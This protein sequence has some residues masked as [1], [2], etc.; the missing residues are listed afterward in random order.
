MLLKLFIFIISLKFIFGNENYINVHPENQRVTLNSTVTIQCRVQP[1]KN[2]KV[3]WVKSG[4]GLGE[5][6]SDIRSFGMVGNKVRYDIPNDLSA[7]N[8]DLQ[9]TDVNLEDEGDFYCQMNIKNNAITS[10]RAQLHVLV[11]SGPPKIIQIGNQGMGPE[12]L[13]NENSPIVVDNGDLMAL[14]C[15]AERGRPGARLTWM[16][17]NEIIEPDLSGNFNGIISGTITNISKK[18]VNNTKLR[19]SFSTLKA[20]VNQLLNGKSI[21]CSATNRGFE[22]FNFPEAKAKIEIHV[23]PT[24]TMDIVSQNLGNEFSENDWI[25]ISCS[26]LGR[27]DKFLW[28]WYINDNEVMNDN[29]SSYKIKAT[30][31]MNKAVVKCIANNG[32]EG[33]DLRMLNVKYGPQ[34]KD[35]SPP[36]YPAN[37]GDD[38]TLTCNTD[39]NP[40]ANI[41]WQRE[42][43]NDIIGHGTILYRKNIQ[44]LDFGTYI[45]TAGVENF[46]LK[47]KKIILAKRIKPMIRENPDHRASL[48]RSVQAKCVI[49]SIPIANHNQIMWLYRGRRLINDNTKYSIS[50]EK[51]V[52]HSISI[53]SINN[54]QASDFGQY[55]CS[56][57]TDLGSASKVMVLSKTS[58][59]PLILIVGG[60]VFITMVMMIVII[61]LCVCKRGICSNKYQKGSPTNRINSNNSTDPLKSPQ[62]E[63]DYQCQ[64][65]FFQW[66]PNNNREQVK[67]SFVRYGQDVDDRSSIRNG[68]IN[69]YRGLDMCSTYTSSIP[70]SQNGEKPIRNPDIDD[71]YKEEFYPSSNPAMMCS[72]HITPTGSG[73]INR[74]SPCNAHPYS[75]PQHQISL[76]QYNFTSFANPPYL[77]N[78]LP[79]SNNNFALPSYPVHSPSSEPGINGGSGLMIPPVLPPI[80]TNDANHNVE[81]G[82]SPQQTSFIKPG[83]TISQNMANYLSPNI[84]PKPNSYNYTLSGNSNDGNSF[85]S[86]TLDRRGPISSFT[87]VDQTT[88][89]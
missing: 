45:C 30:R 80:D 33:H 53:L 34:F 82:L 58:P 2:M 24:V 21:K 69:Q 18:I 78:Y 19:D 73:A 26:A 32:K 79:G 37:I 23:A 25:T 59:I 71:V 4:F 6:R 8:Y 11:A 77:S 40:M 65:N 5:T 54:I 3:Y 39:S 7:G 41:Y 15:Q 75:V 60:T 36:L 66:I 81:L 87:N 55:N 70:G 44:E 50:T 14:R 35:D 56:V 74:A 48:G 84:R 10:Q 68:S 67:S 88:N 64:P 29:R 27:P 85:K 51:Y 86:R 16:I 28:K 38:V 1:I 83:M 13:R 72:M 22:K 12:K 46:D 89:I 61:A 42:S 49:D 9:I 63:M 43:N 62:F 20:K 17:D 76:P 31:T 47:S 52:D 57:T